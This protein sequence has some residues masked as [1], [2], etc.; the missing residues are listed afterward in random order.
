[1]RLLNLVPFASSALALIV[2]PTNTPALVPRDT[3]ISP[4]PTAA[5]TGI[6]FS[7]T[8]YD[9]ITGVT[10][11][12][13][14]IPQRTITIVI[15]TCSHTITP[16]KNGYV[17]PGTCGALY[18][19]YPS[20]GAAIFFSILFGV[21]S[22]SHI[23]LA[24]KF[25]T[26]FAWVVIMGALWE[27]IS[28][29]FRSI[30]TRY[31]QS[32]GIELVS[33][34]FVLLAPLWV[35]AFAYMVLGRLLYF[36]HPARTILSIPASALAFAFVTLDFISFV[37]QLVGGS[38]AGP[39]DPTDKVM[40]GVHIYMGGIGL[41]QFFIFVFLGM[42]IKF[43]LEMKAFERQGS[44][45]AGKTG[46]MKLLWATYASLGFITIRIFFRLIQFSAGTNASTNGLVSHESYFY[47]LEAMPMVFAISCSL[48]IHPGTVFPRGEKMPGLWGLIRGWL[49]CVK[50]RRGVKGLEDGVQ[51]VGKYESLDNEGR[52]PTY[53][54]TPPRKN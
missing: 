23:F 34:L 15:P 46:W 18:E 8:I 30:S 52:P 26:R 43:H 40:Q 17:P 16:D 29:T 54:L 1:M 32:A 50:G 14:K 45:G 48:V 35:N 21:L 9:I 7:T 4:S 2:L 28:F 12:Q 5:P 49:C 20:F 39:N 38:W 13:V 27:T 33:D 19:Y 51:L 25:K 41:Q 36:F 44:L 22:I 10:D 53:V 3:T 42:A 31:Q 37:I 11:D 6:Y 24:A 47:I